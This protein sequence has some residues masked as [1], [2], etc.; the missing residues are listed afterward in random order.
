MQEEWNYFTVQNIVNDSHRR[1][2]KINIIIL[3]I[4]N[5]YHILILKYHGKKKI[6][7]IHVV[8][9]KENIQEQ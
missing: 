3:K 6:Q 9:G 5:M 2:K 7:T 1:S 4:N 8:P